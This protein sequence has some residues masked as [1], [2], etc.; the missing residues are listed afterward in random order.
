[1][2]RLGAK[3]AKH[4]LMLIAWIAMLSCAAMAKGPSIAAHFYLQKDTY[5]VGEPVFLYLEV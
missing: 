2:P 3:V 5:G 4:V 1:M